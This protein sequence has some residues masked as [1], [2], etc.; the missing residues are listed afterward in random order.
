MASGFGPR[1]K[2]LREKAGLTQE[3]LARAAGLSS[4]FVS[5]IE[6]RSPDPSW[7]TV[8]AL[9]RALGVSCEAFGAS[10]EVH[11]QGPPAPRKPIAKRGGKK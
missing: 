10:D 9:A 8:Q 4:S 3:G 11:T 1:L 2:E 6:Q 5:K 7:T